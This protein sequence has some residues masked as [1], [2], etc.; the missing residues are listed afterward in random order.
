MGRM[1]SI[2]MQ[3]Q[4]VRAIQDCLN[5][6]VR[7]GEALEVDGI[8]G[9]KTDARVRQFQQS[10]GL[11]ADGIVGPLTEAAL[12]EVTEIEFKIGMMP[13][14]EL[15]LPSLGGG[16]PGLK[17]PAPSFPPLREPVLD[18]SWINQLSLGPRQFYPES[19][20]LQLPWNQEPYVV[21]N[22]KL[23]APTRKDPEDPAVRSYTTL[24]GWVNQMPV[25]SKFKL[26]LISQVPNPVKKVS[27]PGM[28]FK[29]GMAPLWDPT[30]PTVF[31]L[32]ANAQF[33]VQVSQG[34]GGWPFIYFSAWGD[35]KASVDMDKRQGETAPRTTV[36]GLLMI[37]LKGVI[38]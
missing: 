2:G 23:V 4:D 20:R 25:D 15:T 21:F 10:N 31:G 37:G 38:F 8:F 35:M 18:L 13:R 29:W 30:K 34:Q 28:G 19:T 5:F 16:K 17:L 12:F 36:D 9:Q 24:I 26:F 6:H 32:K 1:L 22:W 27:K 33:N 14:M 11:K 7:R 3:G